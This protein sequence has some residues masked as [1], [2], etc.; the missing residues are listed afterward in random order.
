MKH[1]GENTMKLKPNDKIRVRR[2]VEWEEGFFAISSACLFTLVFLNLFMFAC[3]RGYVD[4]YGP[5]P[6]SF[7]TFC[8][9]FLEIP[10]LWVFVR[11][12]QDKRVYYEVVK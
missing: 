7:F 12:Y 9:G 3:L 8:I 5:I 6:F 2:V 11:C 4:Y 1:T 10:L